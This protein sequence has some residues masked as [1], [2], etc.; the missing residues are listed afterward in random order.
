MAKYIK[1]VLLFFMLAAIIDVVCGY[2]FKYLIS[3]AKGGDSQKN[4]YISEECCDDLLVFGSSRAVRH[5][6]PRVLEDSLGLSC[7]NCGEQGCGIITSYARY[8]L[9]E[10]RHKPKLV[11]YEV[12]PNFDYFKTE[13]YSK[14]LG[15]IRQYSNNPSIKDIFIELGDELEGVRLFSSMYRNNS[16]LVNNVLDN[17]TN[18]RFEKGFKPL[19]GVLKS[20]QKPQKQSMKEMDSLKFSYVEKLI[21]ELKKDNIPMCFYVSPRCIDSTMALE[22]EALYEPIVKLCRKYKVPF[23][24][25]D[26][27]DGISQNQQLFQDFGHLNK[28]G[29]RI[30]SQIVSREVKQYLADIMSGT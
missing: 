18:E 10:Q 21:V 2:G 22:E 1:K 19:K 4:Y 8:R 5:Y 16:F 6:D 15:R 13:D 7:Y 29:A 20:Q 26:Y 14:Y 30:Y 11:I 27:L 3:N 28:E 9:I 12:T 23:I 24:N 25:H 17:L